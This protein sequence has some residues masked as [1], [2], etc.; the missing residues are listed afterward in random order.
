[1]MLMLKNYVLKIGL[2]S[3]MLASLASCTDYQ[4]QRVEEIGKPPKMQNTDL[5]MGRPDFKPVEWPEDQEEVMVQR[6]YS[7][8]LWQPGSRAFFRDNRARR[9]GDILKVI[10]KIQDK[11]ELD[12]Q[13]QR[14]R[15]ASADAQAP[16]LFGLETLATAWLPGTADL[17]N[18]LD[19]SNSHS[20]NGSG[21]TDR[22]EKIETEVAAMVTQILPN[23]NLVIRGDQEIRVNFELR[24]VSVSGIVRPEDISAENHVDS[25]MIAEARISYG[26]R[27]VL[28][29]MQQPPIA[30]QVMD[31]L[32]PF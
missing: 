16:A 26:G 10:V 7:N 29:D 11:A 2:L 12:N 14:N 32:S 25:N 24:T 23:G 31:V 20:T 18:L 9:V 30:H 3:L 21:S 5:P 19:A 6:K 27:G 13:T 22:E 4:M 17:A 28:S 15:D 8:S 1:M